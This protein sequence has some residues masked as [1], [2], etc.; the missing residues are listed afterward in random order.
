MQFTAYL[1]IVHAE[2]HYCRTNQSESVATVF[3]LLAL[4]IPIV[5]SNLYACMLTAIALKAESSNKKNQWTQT[6]CQC[7]YWID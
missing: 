5:K 6:S 1:L 3:P 4:G 7:S 2:H